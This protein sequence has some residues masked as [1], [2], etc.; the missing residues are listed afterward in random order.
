MSRKKLFVQCLSIVAVV[1]VC[2]VVSGCGGDASA[3]EDSSVLSDSA[4]S[5]DEAR[6]DERSFT[7]ASQEGSRESADN[8]S[9]EPQVVASVGEWVNGADGFAVRVDSVEE[10]PYDEEQGMPTVRVVLSMKNMR[11]QTTTFKTSFWSAD[12]SDG[13]NVVYRGNFKDLNGVNVVGCVPSGHTVTGVMYF[14]GEE[15]VDILYQPRLDS[16]EE[17]LVTFEI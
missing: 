16:G 7:E 5:R 10:G 17:Q 4:V 1:S 13:R 14:A 6:P 9:Y 11:N 3:A 8:Y 15:L 12:N 2:L